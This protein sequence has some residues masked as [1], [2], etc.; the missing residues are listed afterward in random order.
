MKLLY[1]TRKYSLRSFKDTDNGLLSKKSL[2]SRFLSFHSQNI[3]SQE[4][5]GQTPLS[6]LLWQHQIKKF[7]SPERYLIHSFEC[8]CQAP[9]PSHSTE[10]GRIGFKQ[11]TEAVT[12]HV[13]SW[14]FYSFFRGRKR[15]TV[16][17]IDLVRNRGHF[18]LHQLTHAKV[19]Q[20]SPNCHDN[21]TSQRQ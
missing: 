20:L 8:Q 11:K 10:A 12:W 15:K 6:C 3:K 2:P 18:Q 14:S 5:F 1:P 4:W 16:C 9:S 17:F 19:L 13:A 7:H 21:Y